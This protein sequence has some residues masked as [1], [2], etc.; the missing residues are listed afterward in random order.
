MDV[1]NI[2]NKL[3]KFSDYWSPKIIAELNGQYVKLAKLKGDFVWHMHEEE[4]E[5]FWVQKG[6]LIMEFRDRT[7]IINEGEM[8]VVPKGVE[9]LPRAKEEVHILLFEPIGTVNTG[10]LESDRKVEKLEKI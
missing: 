9:H 2:K 6:Q 10:N 5:L 7:E 1:I 3:S 4:D 8:I